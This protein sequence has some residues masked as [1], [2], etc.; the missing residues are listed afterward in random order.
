MQ[1]TV[2]VPDELVREAEARGVSVEA[3]AEEVLARIAHEETRPHE[4]PG[5]RRQAVDGMRSFAREHGFTLG[6]GL[7]IKD[8]INEGRKY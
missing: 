3:Y 7:T 6:P 1:I 2:T 8:L 4:T 5:E